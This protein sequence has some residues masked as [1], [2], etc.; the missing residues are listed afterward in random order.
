MTSAPGSGTPMQRASG[1]RVVR[2][3]DRRGGLGRAPRAGHRHLAPGR[4]RRES[5]QP[6]AQR[7][8]SAA[9]ALNIEAQPGEEPAREGRVALQ[10]GEQLRVPGGHVEVDRRRDVGQV[11]DGLAEQRRHRAAVVDRTACRRWS[12]T[13]FTSWLPPNVWLHGSQSTITG[14]S[15]ARN[16]H[17]C[18]IIC[19]LAASMP[20]R[21]Q[22]PLR[23][24][25]RARREQDLGD[26]C[27]GAA[28]AN[29]A[30]TAA[31]GSVLRRVVRGS[32]PG[33]SPRLT[34]TGTPGRA[35]RA[36]AE[37]ARVLGE[38]RTRTRS[39]RRWP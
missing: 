3:V 10:R 32:A 15:S 38:H 29:A 25:G 18:R 16:G 4:L 34:I 14:G 1:D 22:H 37:R 12:S 23:G 26:V 21:V 33:R 5:R 11:R 9:A 30:A 7:R 27:P 19:W 31:P 8:G 2:R 36:G 24:A 35:S 39:A 20:V 28:P 6:L 17:A 13:M